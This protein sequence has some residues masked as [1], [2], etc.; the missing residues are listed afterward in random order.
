MRSIISNEKWAPIKGYEGLYE[1]STK[2]RV[3]RDNKLLHLNSNTYGYLH[4]TLS[5]SNQQKTM[6]VHRLVA[7]TFINNPHE[8][9]QIN[10]RDGNKLNNSV[11]NLEWCTQ[12]INNRHAINT[13][14]RK[15][16][17]IKMLDLNNN[18]IK[19]FNNRME[20]EKYFNRKISRDLITK[21]CNGVR[22][23]AYGYR[24]QYE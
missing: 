2:G 23:T 8:Y 19:V 1:V 13:Q 5:K 14:L 20:I 18:L 10:H 4:V 16:K 15:T 12:L 17:K 21:C 3:Q 6:T 9:P 11:D 22:K 24:W 7:E